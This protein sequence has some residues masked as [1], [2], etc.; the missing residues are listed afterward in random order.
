MKII[1]TIKNWVNPVGYPNNVQII[2]Y[3]FRPLEDI[4]AYEAIQCQ[5]HPRATLFNDALEY[6]KAINEWYDSLPKKC[7][8]HLKFYNQSC[9]EYKPYG[10]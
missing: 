6:Q 10:N 2:A 1:D 9:I 3:E 8:R 7:K 5:R 4:T